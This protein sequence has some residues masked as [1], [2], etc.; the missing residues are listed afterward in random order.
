MTTPM[1]FPLK[2]HHTPNS[3]KSLRALLLLGVLSSVLGSGT[4]LRAQF[5]R[6]SVLDPTEF[7]ARGILY[8]P[9]AGTHEV[10]AR[11]AAAGDVDRDFRP[12]LLIAAPGLADA[13]GS[14]YLVRGEAAGTRPP[15]LLSGAE[16][17]VTRLRSG[18]EGGDGFGVLVA[19]A[20]D[21][22]GD[23]F[24]DY[25]IGCRARIPPFPRAGVFLIFG[26]PQLPDSIRLDQAAPDEAVLFHSAFAGSPDLA[27]AAATGD[28]NGDGFVD[29]AIGFAA[30]ASGADPEPH[31][32]VHV[33]FGGPSLRAGDGVVDLDVAPPT[34]AVT[35]A[36]AENRSRTGGALAGLGDVDGDG[37]AD[38]AVGAAGRGEGGSVYV[39]FGGAAPWSPPDL[40]APD[41]NGVVE[42][43]GPAAGA[44]FGEALAGGLDANGDADGDLLVGAPTETV[45]GIRV[46]AAY[47]LAGAATWRGGDGVRDL[48]ASSVRHVGTRG[49]STGGAVALVPDLTGDG[50]AERLIG[51]PSSRGATGAVYL[52]GS[53]IVD[54]AI[55]LEEDATTVFV[56]NHEGARLGAAIV[57]LEDRSGDGRGDLVLG[58]P[59]VRLREELGTGVAFEVYAPES[60]ASAAPNR[61][62][63]R[64]VT[65]GRVLLTWALQGRYEFLRLFRDGAPITG[66]LPGDFSQFVDAEPPDTTHTYFVEANGDPELRSSS[67]VVELTSLPPRNLRCR[68]LG[69]SLLVHLRWE[70]ADAYGSLQVYVDGAPVGDAL[71]PFATETLVPSMPGVHLFEVADPE[72][73][74]GPRASCVLEVIAPESPEIMDFT[75]SA[76]GEQ[77]VDLQWTPEDAYR[78]YRVFRNGAHIATTAESTFRD[79]GVP[80]GP[81]QYGVRG[82]HREIHFGPLATCGLI[83]APS[84]LPHVRGRIYFAD[85]HQ[86]AVARGV[87]R[88]FTGDGRAVSQT[89][90]NRD[91]EYAAPVPAAGIYRLV[92]QVGF[93][94]VDDPRLGIDR[95]H[96]RP[97]GVE[98]AVVSTE[99]GAANDVVVPVPLFA[100]AYRGAGRRNE[101][102]AAR[103][104]ALEQAAQGV[105]VPGEPPLAT[106]FVVPLTLP[107]GIAAGTSALQQK[108]AAILE[109]LADDFGGAPA[110]Y[111]IV[112]FGAAGLSARVHLATLERREVRRL[113][114]LGTPNLG[115]LR[116][117]VEQRAELPGRV[118]RGFDQDF[119]DVEQAFRGAVEETR[120]FIEELGDRLRARRGAEVHAIAGTGGR[121]SLDAVLGCDVHDDRVCVASALAIDGAVTHTLPENHEQLGRS[122]ASV[123]LILEEI[124]R[125]PQGPAAAELPAGGDGAAAGLPGEIEASYPPSDV[126]QGVL[127]PG[128]AA[129]VPMISDTSESLIILLNTKLPGRL[130][131]EVDLPNGDRIDPAAAVLANVDYETYG[132]GEGHE[133]QFYRIAPAP[134]GVYFAVLENEGVEAVAYTLELYLESDIELTAAVDPDKVGVGTPA[135]ITAAVSNQGAPELGASVEATVTRP[136][137][138]LEIVSLGDAGVGGDL[139]AGD[140]EYAALVIDTNEPGIH[141]IT[142]LA[143]SPV[144]VSPPYSREATVQLRVQSDVA[145]LEDGYSAGVEEGLV[146]EVAEG[147]W[148]EG[149]IVATA[150][151]AYLV[152]ADLMAEGDELVAIGGALVNL[153]AA[154]SK[155]YRMYFDGA[156]IYG[157]KLDGPYTLTHV[158]LRDGGAGFVLADA[159]NDAHVT[160]AY[161]WA[162]FGDAT[163]PSPPRYVRGDTNTDGVRDLSDAVAIL[164]YLFL[165]VEEVSCLDA[166]DA[167]GDAELS[168]TDASFLLNHLFLGGASPPEPNAACGVAPALGCE[169]FPACE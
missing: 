165:G 54:S 51:A 6:L 42:F 32:R 64:I 24:D 61:L 156:D 95:V 169:A 168:I 50:T 58:A 129:Q 153:E 140:G 75:C 10:G 127:E 110:S 151:G 40:A 98:V 164:N 133:V 45:N 166:A 100:L 163:P 142:V 14:V 81:A 35:I 19:G 135:L 139:V 122:A 41:G 144:P 147:L 1:Q 3:G 86:S 108:S 143:E 146:P 137:G 94:G 97:L 83:V 8:V 80:A 18:L 21:V 82:I 43:R 99:A 148:V 84:D 126:N 158:E 13:P 46:G 16:D 77:T 114:L 159:Q 79:E 141:S 157:A 12:D 131:F 93:R 87:V 115:T 36:G 67:V 150:P 76:A 119:A 65:G 44:S 112:A 26:G 73:D 105:L 85:R 145:Q 149:E 37:F 2:T 138:S 66:P 111:D 56:G 92:Y 78:G 125:A 132:D 7:R 155:V 104:S 11:L 63:A 23:G 130:R 106:A 31:G 101:D 69:G 47:L 162:S 68:Q 49:S 74:A 9:I 53:E 55:E 91:G 38:F 107:V 5:P 71:P 117:A 27:S 116:G 48:P 118:G 134:A 57:G 128:G 152:T 30:G 34:V 39:V 15:L 25:V 102:A 161:S 88:L 103:W 89:Q 22:D 20:G 4:G 17:G 167:N 52:V 33:V 120:E 136:D 113:V 62:R 60:D 96:P 121:D 90:P 124:H 154:G 70:I 160:E 109:A 72:A 28:I 59:G 29:L 123:E